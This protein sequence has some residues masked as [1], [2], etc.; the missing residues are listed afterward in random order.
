[1]HFYVVDWEL[2]RDYSSYHKKEEEGPAEAELVTNS[3][4]EAN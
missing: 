4:Q 3:L 1:M 2:K